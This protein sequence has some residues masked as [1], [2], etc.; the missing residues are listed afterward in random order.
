MGAKGQLPG[1]LPRTGLFVLCET[2][3]A[4]KRARAV[5]GGEFLRELYWYF[6]EKGFVNILLTFLV[7]LL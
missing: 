7:H 6:S 5:P 3:Q 2:P 4:G 1:T